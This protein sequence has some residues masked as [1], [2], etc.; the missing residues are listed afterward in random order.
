MTPN[1]PSPDGECRICG[2]TYTQRG[3]SQHLKSCVEK[4]RSED[5]DQTRLYH[6]KA[7]SHTPIFWL[8][9]EIESTS[10]LSV[11]DQ[12]L[13][14]IWLECCGHLSSF[15]IGEQR[16]SVQPMES[17]F[18]GPPEKSVDVP[19][20]EVLR[21][22][23]SF[24]YVY[25]FGSSTHLD[26]KVIDTRMGPEPDG[27]VRLLARNDRPDFRCSNCDEPAT[28]ICPYCWD[29]NMFCED[30]APEHPC[31]DDIGTLLPLVNSPR[32]GVCGYTGPGENVE[33]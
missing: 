10:N 29:N 14:D 26:L 16:Y 30:C 18:G 21:E 3:I 13:R 31:S 11:V 17:T 8:H 4:N 25:D 7:Q 9:F 22:G 20:C 24:D 12:F 6:L 1:A 27:P 23:M 5:D 28:R 19:V 2:S 33:W 15:T 32:S